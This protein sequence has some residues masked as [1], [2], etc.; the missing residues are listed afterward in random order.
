MG[1]RQESQ[2]RLW[3]R[4]PTD[5]ANSRNFGMVAARKQVYN[6]STPGRAQEGAGP[7]LRGPQEPWQHKGDR[8]QRVYTMSWTPALL[9]LL[10]HC[11]GENTPELATPSPIPCPRLPQILMRFCVPRLWLP[12]SAEPAAIGVLVPRNH[13]PPALH[14]EQRP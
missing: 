14:L 12:A 7:A 6:G 10:A 11:I 1:P 9:V 8:A 2:R 5:T 13:N 3:D 4:S